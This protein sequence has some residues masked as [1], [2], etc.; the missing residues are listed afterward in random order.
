MREL[1][2]YSSPTFSASSRRFL[3]RPRADLLDDQAGGQRAELAAILQ[4]RARRVAEQEAGGVEVAGAG[5]VD[6]FL[7]L[8]RLDDD[9]LVAATR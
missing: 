1:N 4:A 8:D 9:G 7:D 5:R 3:P 2:S 6:Q